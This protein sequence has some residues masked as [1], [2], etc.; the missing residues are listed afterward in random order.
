MCDV[1]QFHLNLQPTGPSASKMP[2]ALRIIRRTV[3]GV[4]GAL[5]GRASVEFGSDFF[6]QNFGNFLAKSRSF[7]D[8]SAPIFARKYALF[9]FF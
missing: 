8:A 7:S 3:R 4:P 6:W 2:A 1:A 5:A 9:S